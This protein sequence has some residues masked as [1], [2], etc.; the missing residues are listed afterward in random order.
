MFNQTSN[1]EENYLISVSDI[2]SGLIFIFIITL[3]VFSLQLRDSQEQQVIETVKLQEE[4]EQSQKVRHELE[5]EIEQSQKVRHELER[6]IHQ[7]QEMH[8]K[9]QK[10]VFRYEEILNTLTNARGLRKALL[11][12][13]EKSLNEKGFNVKIDVDHGVLSLPEQVLF[14]S[15]SDQIQPEGHTMLVNLSTILYENLRPFTFDSS[16]NS[17]FEETELPEGLLPSHIEAIFIEGHTD[18]VPVSSGSRFRDNWDLSTARSYSTFRTLLDSE[19]GLNN[20]FNRSGY[21]I[22]C[23]SGYAEFRPVAN[24]DTPEGRSLNR[25][26]DIRIIMTPPSSETKDQQFIIPQEDKPLQ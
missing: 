9:L 16:G 24:N 2:M 12:S 13:I 20:L 17:L 10:Q 18:N 6:E 25:R 23:V 5:E 1:S 22:F 7:Y 26:I 21:P 14:P 19:P 4:I 8:Q 3:A 11:I 15:G